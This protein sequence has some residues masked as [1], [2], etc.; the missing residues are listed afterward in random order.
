MGDGRSGSRGNVLRKCQL[1]VR[2]PL[3]L[4]TDF[5]YQIL[6]RVMLIQDHLSSAYDPNT[7]VGPHRLACVF[8]I[9]AL[10]CMFDLDRQPCES[11]HL[12]QGALSVDDSRGKQ[13]FD[14]GKA[15][16]SAVGL[17]HACPASIQAIHLCGTFLLNG[18][19]ARQPVHPLTSDFNGAEVF[20]PMLGNAVKAAQSVSLCKRRLLISSSDC[21][22]TV[23]HS[24]YRRTKWRRDGRCGGN[25][26]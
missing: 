11:S 20:W 12:F 3:L 4:L 10:G 8:F 15:C 25:S 9:M 26:W 14:L 2:R 19:G 23:L 1:D 13:L 5:R 6:P 7:P 16:L 18:T 22:A 17:E 21:T 24:V